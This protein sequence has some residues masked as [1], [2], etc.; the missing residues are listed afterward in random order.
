[1]SEAQK[2][3]GQAGLGII[4]PAAQFAYGGNNQ[5][6]PIDVATAV[7]ASASASAS[8]RQDFESETFV[9]SVT[10]QTT[11]ALD[12][13]NNGK[14]SSEDG[15]G[16][17][18]PTIAF[19]SKDHGGD[20]LE[21]TSP[22]LRAM[23]HHGSHANAGGQVAVAFHENQRAE[24]SLSETHGSLKAGGGKPG[25]GYPA[26]AIQERAVCENPDAGPGGAGFRSDGTSYTL[27]ARQVPQ[28]VATNMQVRR[29]TPTECERL[30]GFPDDYTA[31][32]WRKKPADQCPDGP[33]YK[34]LGNSMAVP[35][36][37]WIGERIQKQLSTHL[38]NQEHHPMP[39]TQLSI[40]VDLDPDEVKSLLKTITSRLEAA[41][42]AQ[43]AAVVQTEKAAKAAA[44][45]PANEPPETKPAKKEKPAAKAEATYDDAKKAILDLSSDKGREAAVA[46]LAKFGAGKL[47]EV[48]ESKYAE[49]VAEAQAAMV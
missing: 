10:G 47:P 30:Q 23:G 21:D 41:P 12:T 11:H 22:T 43:A 8:G 33:R 44:E 6:G 13:C 24:I 5:R 19:S 25:Q 3:G 39:T 28:A 29:L 2:K 37:R 27:E 17:G 34:A 20:A 36:M 7:N 16:R 45:A 4:A 35:V 48:D 15:T 38:P 46:V 42:S 18:V 26:I 40:T 31:I 9:T 49:V 32:P 1:M 14:G